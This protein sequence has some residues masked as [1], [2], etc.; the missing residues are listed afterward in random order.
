MEFVGSDAGLG[1]LMLYA[2]TTLD[3]NQL[4]AALAVLLLMD[5]G[6]CSLVDGIQKLFPIW[7][8]TDPAGTT[9]GGPMPG[10]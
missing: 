4:F 7:R 10:R 6:L 9:A 3:T 2:G 8:R 1:Y 5:L